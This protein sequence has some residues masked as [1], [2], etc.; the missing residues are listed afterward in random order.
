MITSANRS[1]LEELLLRVKR[2]VRLNGPASESVA[3][4]YRFGTGCCIDFDGYQITT[5]DGEIK[6]VSPSGRRA[7]SG[8][9]SRV[10]TKWSAGRKSSK[11]SGAIPPSPKQGPLTTS[12]LRFGNT[13][14]PIPKSRN[15]SLPCAAL[16]TDF[17]LTKK[18]ITPK[19]NP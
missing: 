4:V 18:K 5:R 3:S 17:W 15:T 16:A 9:S 14:S 8:S 12:S 1:T 19:G 7:C 6:S 2:L 10:R 11:L 13:L